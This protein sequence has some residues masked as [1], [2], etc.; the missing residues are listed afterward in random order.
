MRALTLIQPWASLIVAGAKRIEN[1]T[2]KPPLNMAGQ[3]FAIHAGKKLDADV[4]FD[5]QDRDIAGLPP[6]PPL[7][8][9]VGVATLAGYVTSS[10][11]CAR[12]VGADQC[13]WFFGPYGFVLE[14]VRPISLLDLEVKGALSFWPLAPEITAAIEEQLR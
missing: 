13:E 7:G 6:V 12:E 8:R 10:E 3:R 9:I 4:L 1:R 2:W 14:D 5:L 11:Q